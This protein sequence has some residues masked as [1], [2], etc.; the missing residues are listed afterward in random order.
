MLFAI[1]V[2]RR[3]RIRIPSQPEVLNKLIAFFI[4]CQML[5]RRQFLVG[6]DPAHVLIHPGLVRA[7]QAP[8]SARRSGADSESRSRY[9]RRIRRVWFVLLHRN[10]GP[11]RPES[12]A[13]SDLSAHAR[14]S[15][16]PPGRTI[17]RKSGHTAK[18]ST[19][20]GMRTVSKFHKEGLLLSLR[21]RDCRPNPGNIQ[22]VSGIVKQLL[23]S[24]VIL[25]LSQLRSFR[26]NAKSL[27]YSICDSTSRK[28]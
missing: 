28:R 9:A 24:A 13:E 17:E 19:T 22:T 21:N 5:E 15:S 16:A 6:D 14:K 1:F 18:A 27:K 20:R 11:H 7:L 4:V 2:V 3:V 12:S 25:R 8:A 10:L 23:E 26:R